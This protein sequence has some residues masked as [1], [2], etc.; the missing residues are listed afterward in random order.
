MHMQPNIERTVVS[1]WVPSC[2]T[3]MRRCAPESRGCSAEEKG[4]TLPNPL[5]SFLG[6]MIRDLLHHGG[7]RSIEREMHGI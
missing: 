4:S 3:R 1:M 7:G 6:S 2:I 5:A